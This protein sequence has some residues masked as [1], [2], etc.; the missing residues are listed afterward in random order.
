MNTVHCYLQCSSVILIS[1]IIYGGR[2]KCFYIK[3]IVRSCSLWISCLKLWLT[4]KQISALNLFWKLMYINYFQHFCLK[5]CISSWSC[6]SLISAYAFILCSKKLYPSKDLFFF[7]L[8][9]TN[10]YVAWCLSI[11]WLVCPTIFFTFL[12]SLSADLSNFTF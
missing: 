5:F 8:C 7:L 3:K 6:P 9:L 1:Y 11:C 2:R 10:E 4:F 12:H